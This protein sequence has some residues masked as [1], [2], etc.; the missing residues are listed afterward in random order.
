MLR[1]SKRLRQEVVRQS[2][3]CPSE[4]VGGKLGLP[5][6][7]RGGDLALGEANRQ[8]RELAF[9]SARSPRKKMNHSFAVGRL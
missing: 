9:L 3:A 1:V 2:F 8:E 6:M 4:R 5:L 7:R